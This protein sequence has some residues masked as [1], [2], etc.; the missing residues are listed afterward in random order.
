LDAFIPFNG[1]RR[2]DRGNSQNGHEIEDDVQSLGDHDDQ[3]PR[4]APILQAE[5]SEATNEEI[6]H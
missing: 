5:V 2:I 1:E 6:I 4:I 3:L